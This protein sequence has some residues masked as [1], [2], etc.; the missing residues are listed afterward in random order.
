MGKRKARFDL[1]NLEIK[2]FR[3]RKLKKKFRFKLKNR[4]IEGGKNLSGK[5]KISFDGKFERKIKWIKKIGKRNWKKRIRVE[6]KI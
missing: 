4:R 2:K 5:R 6:L 1:R 3:I